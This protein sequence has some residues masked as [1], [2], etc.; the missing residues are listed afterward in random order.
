M[1]SKNVLVI[2]IQSLKVGCTQGL[3]NLKEKAD[4]ANSR[5]KMDTTILNER[6]GE[7]KIG[8]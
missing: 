8:S 2:E 7:L 1:R 5:N 3:G 6:R 4:S